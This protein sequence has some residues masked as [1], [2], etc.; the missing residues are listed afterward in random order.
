MSKVAVDGISVTELHTRFVTARP[1]PHLVLK[2]AI[3]LDR[4]SILRD[5]PVPEWSG[6][7]RFRDGYQ[8]QKM[9]YD[10]I[11]GMP[12]SLAGVIHQLNA[13]AFLEFLEKITGIEGLI[14]DPHLQG[15]GLHCSGPGGILAPHTDFHLYKRLHLYRRINLLLYLNPG[16]CHEDGGCLELYAKGNAVPVVTVVPEWGS[17]VI[18]QTDDNSIHG[19]SHPIQGN[20]WR[21]SIALYYY[22]AEEAS[23][24][25]GDTTTHWKTHGNIS[26]LRLSLYKGLI[27]GS[28][29]LSYLAYRINPRNKRID[30][31]I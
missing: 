6:W 4:A 1:F 22:T 25:S 19:F 14:P 13:P 2:D 8:Y 17:M 26:R 20:Q 18:F 10:D 29:A 3:A 11:D 27:F 23:R 28:R 9:F 24:F 7:H 31:G 12:A 16:W 30:R 15:G 21:K 5:F